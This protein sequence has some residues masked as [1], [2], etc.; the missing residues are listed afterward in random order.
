M[1]PGA[2]LRRGRHAEAGEANRVHEGGGPR[3]LHDGYT[4]GPRDVGLGSHRGNLRRDPAVANA[5][6]EIEPEPRAHRGDPAYP[7]PRSRCA[8]SRR[9]A[10][11]L[12]DRVCANG[13]PPPLGP[14]TARTSDG[15]GRLLSTV[16]RPVAV[17]QGEAHDDDRP[18]GVPV[19]P[20]PR[21]EGESGRR[22]APRRV[23]AGSARGDTRLD[24]ERESMRPWSDLEIHNR[25]DGTNPRKS[26]LNGLL[27]TGFELQRQ[28]Y[29]PRPQG[30]CAS[31]PLSG[32]E[33]RHHTVR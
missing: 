4:D 3:Q 8:G 9:I 13:H 22:A 12:V 6:H 27:P 14:R 20:E 23:P 31:G 7:V 24:P 16:P 17:R 5:Q 25:D 26:A 15:P 32:S 18:G 30:S 28:A 1:A 2:F 19:E 11:R 10:T 21:S 33:V 29:A